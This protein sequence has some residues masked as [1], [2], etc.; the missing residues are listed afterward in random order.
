M[1]SPFWLVR[2]PNNF[3]DYYFWILV[4]LCGRKISFLSFLG[5]W[6]II[7]R[8][9]FGLQ[10]SSSSSV[11]IP[12]TDS[13]RTLQALENRDFPF[14]QDFLLHWSWFLVL[15]CR[16][17]SLPHSQ[18]GSIHVISDNLIPQIIILR[19]SDFFW[20]SFRRSGLTLFLGFFARVGNARG[21]AVF[22]LFLHGSCR[23]TK[24]WP[25]PSWW[26]SIDHL[27]H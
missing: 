16:P 13:T 21:C 24:S 11:F 27:P 3:S 12:G 7:T 14:F 5:L 10:S 23:C 17:G 20:N 4:I 8:S 18:L 19:S 15:L 2:A 9:L 22:E 26:D 25:R 1:D 6:L